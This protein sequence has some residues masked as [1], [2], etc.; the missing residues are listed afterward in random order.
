MYESIEVSN[1][2]AFYRITA[3]F[4]EA[5]RTLDE[6][7]IARPVSW[8]ELALARMSQSPG[9]ALSQKGAFVQE[10]VIYTE[11][12]PTYYVRESPLLQY[13]YC[14]AAVKLHDLLFTAQGTPDAH[15]GFGEIYFGVVVPRARYEK[16]RTQAK[17]DAKKPPEERYVFT[18]ATRK[19]F[20]IPA[21]EFTD[22][23]LMRFLFRSKALAKSYGE[24][25]LDAGITESP[26]WLL[27]WLEPFRYRK[28]IIRQLYFGNVPQGSSV[29][30]GRRLGFD[31]GAMGGTWGLKEGYE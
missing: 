22:H 16:I 20:R 13:D 6:L 31:D 17:R 27:D 24:F 10:A 12:G 11:N 5:L 21:G 30:G 14:T 25:L 29:N 3:P 18:L 7:H 9:N 4:D 8:H 28:P 26:I 2:G 19:N 23:D 1:L 15:S